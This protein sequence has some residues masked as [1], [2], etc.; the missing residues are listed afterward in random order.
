MVTLTLK[1]VLPLITHIINFSL[2]SGEFPE[3]W[4]SAFVLPIPKV[5][6]PNILN[7]FRPISILPFL[8]KI[9]E[10]VVHKQLSDFVFKNKLVSPFQSGFR[11]GHSTATALLRI[12]EDVREGMENSKLTILVLIDFSNA[13]NTV[14]HD[15]LLA[16]LS[17]LGISSPAIDWFAT[18]LRGRRQAVRIDQNLSDWYDLDAGVPQGGILS[19]LLFSLFINFITKAL[20]CSYH[21]YADDLQLY[22]LTDVDGFVEATDE[23][24]SGLSHIF[25]WASRFGVSVNPDKCHAII[26]GSSQQLSKL[27]LISVPPIVVNNRP[28]PYE[29]QVKDLGLIFD[30]SLSWVAFIAFLGI[31]MSWAIN[32]KK[33]EEPKDKREAP[34]G[35]AGAGLSSHTYQAPS[36]GH[37][38]ASAISVGAGYSVGGA[39]P[40]FSFGG[41]HG[42]SA[43]YQLPS[44]GLQS[45]GHATLKLAPITLQ[46]SHGLA[47]GDLSQLMSQLSHSLNAGGYSLQPASGLEGYAGL[48]QADNGGHELSIPQYS[49][50]SPNLQQYTLS[51]QSVASVPSYAAG[52]KGLGSYGS[53][54]PV[55]FTP[56]EAH[57]SSAALSYPGLSGGHSFGDASGSGLS[58]G[59]APNAGHSFGSSSGHSYGEGSV[60]LGGSGHSLGGLSLGGSGNSYG[61]LYKSLGASYAAPS[62]TAFKPSAYLGSVQ[63]DSSHGLSSLAGSHDLSSFGG[64]SGGSHG[65]SLSSGGHGGSFGGGFG[66][67][68]SGSSKFIAPSY[69]PTKSEGFGSLES[70]FSSG[71]HLAS[72]PATTYGVPSASFALSSNNAHAASSSKPQFYLPSSKYHSFGQGSSSYKAPLSSHSALGSFSSGPKYSFGGHGHSNARYSS[73][74]DA[75][76]SFSENSYNTIKYS[77]ELKPRGH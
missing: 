36:I 14:D 69:A 34:L 3:V 38:G 6:S 44:E 48:Q 35:Y 55:L 61:G 56:S 46:P 71:G 9:L 62:K 10:A 5:P 28:I 76:G 70:S 63:G 39:K 1:H 72:P 16:L 40:S 74:K 20:K 45:S 43:A 33:I 11:P 19:P 23:L 17:Y 15:I 32:V 50:G 25:N 42:A 4:L 57:A 65:L 8:S 21:L 24:N 31:S 37:E 22:H 53:T 54:G 68:G 51:E 30:N 49:Y 60:S 13:F 73:P 59:A 26:L 7:D 64:S 47:A 52:T 41:G 27:N 29:S 75:H 77:E 18:Y 12:T 58:F 2:L 67:F 66:G